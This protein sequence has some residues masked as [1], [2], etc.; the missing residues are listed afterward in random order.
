M[1]TQEA[2][3]QTNSQA[4]RDLRGVLAAFLTALGMWV[5]IVIGLLGLVLKILH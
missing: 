5:F 3:R 2:S 4:G 1:V